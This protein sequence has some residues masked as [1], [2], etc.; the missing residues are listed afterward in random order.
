MGLELDLKAEGTGCRPQL[1]MALPVL[2]THY[3]VFTEK[4]RESGASQRVVHGNAE[5]DQVILTSP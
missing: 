1:C 5:K 4:E 2:D 3:K